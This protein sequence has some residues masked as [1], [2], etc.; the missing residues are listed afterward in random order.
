[1]RKERRPLAAAWG[2]SPGGLREALRGQ[3]P[4]LVGVPRPPVTSG[5]NRLALTS[6]PPFHL[7]HREWAALLVAIGSAPDDEPFTLIEPASPDV[8]LVDPEAQPGVT[9]LQVVDQAAPDACPLRRRRDEQGSDVGLDM[10]DE[11]EHTPGALRQP[12]VGGVQVLPCDDRLLPIQ[13]RVGEEQVP[14]A[15]GVPPHPEDG[16][17][18]DRL[19]RPDGEAAVRRLARSG[20]T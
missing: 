20:R 16:A 8:G 2:V 15:G 4:E 11:A 10:S 18:V 17:V 9:A 13:I 6:T 12:D 14:G 19:S 3:L 5:R 7:K 1:M